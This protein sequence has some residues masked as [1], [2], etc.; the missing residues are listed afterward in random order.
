MKFNI[1]D[2]YPVERKIWAENMLRHPFHRMEREIENTILIPRDGHDICSL[3]S[4]YRVWMK[5][6]IH[7]GNIESQFELELSQ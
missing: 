1:N 4:Q 5:W 7:I 6:Y 3:S 2:E